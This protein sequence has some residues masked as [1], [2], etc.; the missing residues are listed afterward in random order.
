M[1]SSEMRI[2][3]ISHNNINTDI[4]LKPKGLHLNPRGNIL[5]SENFMHCVNA[6]NI[7]CMYSLDSAR[8]PKTRNSLTNCNPRYGARMPCF[9]WENL[10]V[11]NSNIHERVD[12]T[13]YFYEISNK[14]VNI[15]EI[16]KDFQTDHP[17]NSGNFDNIGKANMI[18]PARVQ[19]RPRTGIRV[20]ENLEN[21]ISSERCKICEMDEDPSKILS[22]CR[23][24]NLSRHIIRHININFL[25]SKFE[26]LKSLIK[27]T[28]DIF[29][30]TET[31]IDESYTTSPF[32]IEGFGSPFRLDRNKHGRG[33]M[34][35]IRE[36]L[37]CKLI[38]FHNK[39]KDIETILFGLTRNKKWL[40][41]GAYHPAYEPFL[42]S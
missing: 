36:H 12:T 7:I 14:I 33:V 25:E 11:G 3:F 16:I 18:A 6:W 4:H 13:Q 38:P 35:Y 26:A 37:P 39:P 31:K 30:V 19:R 23:S 42:I 15:S 28:L 2:G 40:I 8:L 9:F 32:K 5:L 10:L 21:P 20:I 1:K 17:A 24:K 22:Q 41:M 29:V 34:V 27:D